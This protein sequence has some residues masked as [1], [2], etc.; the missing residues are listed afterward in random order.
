MLAGV[1]DGFQA[2]EVDRRLDLR[3]VPAEWGGVN[4]DGQRGPAGHR[5]QRGQQPAL[6]Q[7]RGIDAVREAAQ[8]VRC[9]P[10]VGAEL[11]QN[12]QKLVVVAFGQLAGQAQLDR[13]GGEPLLGAVVQV[14][15]DPAPLT[16]GRRH[17]PGPR[18]LQFARLMAQL[19]N[20]GGQR[21]AE[22]GV[23]GGQFSPLGFEQAPLREA[24]S[25]AAPDAVPGG[26][27]GQAGPGAIPG[28]RAEQRREN[29]AEA[30]DGQRA[31]GRVPG[32]ARLEVA[33][34]PQAGQ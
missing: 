15:L 19:L 31:P 33:G 25:Q 26:P 5:G 17:D 13:Q 22:L 11:G 34:D 7:D 18:S 32:E 27:D 21:G 28:E 12:L 24:R 23:M 2:A 16:V 4:R 14:A 8:L 6:H 30:R 29:Q 10:D 20:R 3:G 9:L 1:L